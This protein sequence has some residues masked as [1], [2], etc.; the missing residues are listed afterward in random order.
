MNA[1]SCIQFH[2]V[3]PVVA[4]F[5]VTLRKNTRVIWGGE[6]QRKHFGHISVVEHSI[7]VCSQ[8]TA[9]QSGQGDLTVCLEEDHVSLVE[10]ASWRNGRASR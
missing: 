1:G 5:G 6:N 3:T 10:L 7:G 2:Q 8:L 9:G 4:A